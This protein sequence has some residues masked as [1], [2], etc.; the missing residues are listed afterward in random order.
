MKILS[1]VYLGYKLLHYLR[2]ENIHPRMETKLAKK[3][4]RVAI[5]TTKH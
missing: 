3:W 1:W 5:L 2:L 4:E